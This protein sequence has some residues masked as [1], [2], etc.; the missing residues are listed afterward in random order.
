MEFDPLPIFDD[1][2]Y[3]IDERYSAPR[4]LFLK[5]D[6]SNEFSL[7]VANVPAYLPKG[8]LTLSVLFKEPRGVSSALAKCQSVGPYRVCDFCKV[9]M[10]SVLQ[11]SVESYRKLFHS[12]EEI[13]KS[14][15][16]FIKK[17]DEEVQET[18]RLAKRKFT[19][20]DEDG[21]IT[22]TKAAK[23]VG[24]PLKLKKNEVP[25]MG[26]LRKRKNHVDLAFYSFDKKNAREKKVSEKSWQQRVL[27]EYEGDKAM[28]IYVLSE[29]SDF[30]EQ[31]LALRIQRF[32]QCR[33]VLG[34][35][36]NGQ[37]SYINASPVSI[38]RAH[39][40]YI[41]AQGPLENTCNDFW[42]MVW[43]Q[44]VPAVIM[45]NRIVENGRDKCATYFPLETGHKVEFN[46][47]AVELEKEEQHQNFVVRKLL[48][49]KISEEDASGRAVLHVQYTEWPDFG[50]PAST[51]C[52]LN[53]LNFIKDQNVLST[54][55]GEPPCVVHC[56]AGIGRSGTFIIVDGVLRMIELGIPDSE[57]SLNDLLVDLRCQRFGLIQT[58]QQLMFS[59][60]AIIDALQQRNVRVSHKFPS[61]SAINGADL[62]ANASEDKPSSI[63]RK[64]KRKTDEKEEDCVDDRLAKR[65]EMVAR[66]VARSRESEAVRRGVLGNLSNQLG[67]SRSSLF[68]ASGALIFAVVVGYYVDGS[69]DDTVQVL[70]FSPNTNE[71]PLLA[72]GSWDGVSMM[73]FRFPLMCLC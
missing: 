9:E 27:E 42:Q 37:D 20:P 30:P 67:I 52:F 45:L 72:A 29:L 70:R 31:F 12:P 47:F 64:G 16:D 43:E 32:D 62:D 6:K 61:N 65:R 38:R 28:S 13:E 53:M 49:K 26:G 8:Q 11:N 56:S 2:R 14:V 50:V 44:K 68:A 59:W 23:K 66:M 58:P 3:S 35:N 51:R 69:P 34:S 5:G 24:K 17:Q 10:P 39:R 60:H 40:N 4:Q 48:L 36:A 21:W 55:D 15:A 22:V 63:D 18:K 7:I 19:E 71:K 1:L 33:I 46:D 73:S 41:L 25:L 54:F 57:I